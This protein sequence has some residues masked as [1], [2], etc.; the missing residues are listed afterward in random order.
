[1]AQSSRIL[2][3]VPIALALGAAAWLFHS[4]TSE[5]M[6]FGFS[7]EAS[8]VNA[9]TAIEA[10]HDGTS[11]RGV[12]ASAQRSDAPALPVPATDPEATGPRIRLRVRDPERKPIADAKVETFA[13]STPGTVRTDAEGWCNLP[14]P[15]GGT[16]QMKIR[17]EAKDFYHGQSEFGRTREIQVQLLRQTSV[18]GVLRD[19]QS[20]RPVAAAKVTLPHDEC[21]GCEAEAAVSAADGTFT[22]TVPIARNV[23]FQVAA[24]G[25][26]R[27]RFSFRLPE[28]SKDLRHEFLLQYGTA[29]AGRVLDLRTRAPIA[30]ASVREDNHTEVTRSASDGTFRMLVVPKEDGGSWCGVAAP[31]HCA[32]GM[33]VSAAEVSAGAELQILLPPAVRIAGTVRDSSG[34]PVAEATVYVGQAWGQREEDPRAQKRPFPELPENC[35]LGTEDWSDQQVKTDA[36]GRYRTKGL[37]P[38]RYYQIQVNRTGL[39]GFR[40]NLG[41]LE[42]D[43]EEVQFD[44]T[45]NKRQSGGVINGLLRCN[46]TPCGGDVSWKGPSRNGWAQADSEGVFKLEGVEPGAVEISCGLQVSRGEGSGFYAALR[47][48]DAGQKLKVTVIAG[49]EQQVTWD[50]TFAMSTITGTVRRAGGAPAADVQIWAWDQPN[51]N[52]H[53][54]ART[55][56]DGTYQL[57]V[58]GKVANWGVQAQG[59]DSSRK[60]APGASGVD[61]LIGERG[62][63]RYRTLGPDGLPVEGVRVVSRRGADK[64]FQGVESES[65]DLDGF[66]TANQ[67]RGVA[68]LLA[69]SSRGG[70]APVLQQ[71]ITIGTT[72][73]QV[74]FLMERGAQV[75][76]RLAEGLGNLQRY[77]LVEEALAQAGVKPAD[78]QMNRRQQLTKDRPAVFRGIGPGRVLLQSLDPNV[79]IDPAVIDVPR[80]SD[81]EVVVS[82]KKKGEAKK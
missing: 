32:I 54:S 65:P 15:P 11:A 30:N 2:L 20:G 7:D 68:D 14:L 21:S 24:Q 56:Q 9:A 33:P 36:E 50:V 34:A 64:G 35:N 18:H 59:A 26:P 53:S 76:L 73:V 47:E 25:F 66:R 17:V 46:G 16:R 5:P 23:A 82:W 41:I 57:E 29:I 31:G 4:V 40:K 27:Q 62:T 55:A 80:G 49:E 79:E 81:L 42:P 37:V 60:A 44:V 77:T 58:P 61:F 69:Y 78:I 22:F 72:P 3:L 8:A 28:G 12:D 63:L 51:S 45:L 38:L 19:R 13:D 71:G 75:T 74:D 1:M 43:R 67:P 48:V 39:E 52:M 70:Y 10:S 6:V